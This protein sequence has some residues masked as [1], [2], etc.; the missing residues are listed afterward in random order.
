M[1]IVPRTKLT[2]EKVIY[3]K[4]PLRGI[5][6]GPEIRESRVMWYA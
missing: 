1:Q 5:L 3:S 6:D 2:Y 4:E